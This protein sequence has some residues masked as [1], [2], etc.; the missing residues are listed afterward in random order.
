MLA[1]VAMVGNLALALPADAATSTG[2]MPISAT[3]VATCTVSATP[4]AFG[5]Y[6]GV[7]AN[8]TATITVQCTNGASPWVGLDAGGGTHPAAT[9]TSR[10]MTG[11]TAG[12]LYQLCQN[13][14]CTTN[15][16]NL[17]GDSP[18]AVLSTGALTTLTV[19]GRIAAGQFTGA[20]G[21]YTDTVT[22]TVNY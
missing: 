22:A 14:G 9:T 15:W 21:T 8:S 19:Y 6:S 12:L 3:V 2:T 10:N 4:M 11:G 1:G 7:V 17:V 16:G 20:P 13:V 18:A 5:N